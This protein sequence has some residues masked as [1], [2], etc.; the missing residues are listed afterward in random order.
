MRCPRCDVETPPGMKFCGQC[1]APL[2]SACPACGAASPPGHRF[3][4]QCA[5]SLDKDVGPRFGSPESS[6]VPRAYFGRQ[7][8]R[9]DQLEFNIA[10]K[11]TPAVFRLRPRGLTRRSALITRTDPGDHATP[12]PVIMPFRSR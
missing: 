7:I 8:G 10:I 12:I 11:L 1:A 3:C 6:V 9:R 4:G 5:A 2:A